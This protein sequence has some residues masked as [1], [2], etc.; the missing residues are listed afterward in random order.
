M[1]L[2]LRVCSEYEKLR[3]VLVHRPGSEIECLTPS[4]VKD[5]LFDD[6]PFLDKIQEEHDY[7]VK[8]LKKQGV[9]VYYFRDLL[10]D[11]LKIEHVREEI[12]RK[13]LELHK[14]NKINP[15][16]LINLDTEA[17]TDLLIAGLTRDEWR[18]KEDEKFYLIP[19]LPNLYFTRDIGAV[20]CNGVIC[21][22]MF[23]DIRARESLLMRY[24]FTYHPL[25]QGNPVF[26]D[27]VRES[28][29]FAIEGGDIVVIN[30]SVVAIGRGERTNHRT[31]EYVAKRLFEHTSVEKVY[32][33]E[34]PPTRIC[35]HLD[36][37]FTIIDEDIVV[38][39]PE[40]LKEKEK[41]TVYRRSDNLGFVVE[42]LD[43]GF[44][45]VLKEELGNF[46]VVLTGGGDG[47][48]AEREQWSNGTN[49][50]AVRP[51]VV[52]TYDRNK[53]TNK[54]LRE[55]LGEKNVIEIPSSELIRGR[56]GPRCMTMPL[57]RG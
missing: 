56:G 42:K 37:V 27:N 51:G 13:I 41:I 49:T 33:V 32:E 48:A 15:D 50:L 26:F 23:Y 10:T 30:E 9:S 39:Y 45:S 3:A 19:P 40:V 55:I 4:N 36:T 52:I 8:I 14:C 28:G 2:R 17:L 38:V 29:D 22:K 7:F 34:V 20:I 25:F 53:K 5:F 24:I 54:V 47:M 1:R 44:L 43:A 18:R 35:L 11:I 16:L 31:I 57:I 21:T 6:I 12:I 46:T